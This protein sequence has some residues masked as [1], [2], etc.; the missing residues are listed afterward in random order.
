M[1]A[2][3]DGAWLDDAGPL[4]RP[5]AMTRGRARP[6]KGDLDMMTMV[7]AARP[8]NPAAGLSLEH[9][10]VVELC[11]WPIS[12]AE[13]ASRFEVPLVV[14]KVLVSDLVNTHDIVVRPPDDPGQSP[15][16]N[17]LQAVLDGIRR[18]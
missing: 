18:L 5:Y 2:G 12:V 4:V 6:A 10:R 13:L 15:D 9:E 7:G 3:D 1:T 8:A 17:T 14:A 16:T 11:Q